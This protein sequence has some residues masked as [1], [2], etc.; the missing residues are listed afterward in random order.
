M[1]WVVIFIVLFNVMLHAAQESAPVNVFASSNNKF[2]FPTLLQQFHKHYPGVKVIVQYGAT[3]DLANAILEGVGY[4]LFLGANMK[5]PQ[6]I[7]DAKLAV[8][9][10]KRYAQGILIFLVPADATLH[11]KRLKALVDD[12]IKHITIANK[13]TAPYGKAAMEALKN[14]KMLQKVQ[15]KVVYSTD[16]ST[17]VLN[18]IWYDNAGFL[19]KSAVKTL[20]KMYNKEGVNWIEVDDNLYTPIIQGYVISKK[21]LNNINCQRFIDFIFSKEGREIY[22]EFG[23]K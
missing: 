9:P 21:G 22:K 7:Y 18:V 19:S 12:K 6:K 14:S 16:I 15:N 8:N 3:G 5:Y 2:L 13:K 4:D 1:K 11:N 20:P 23:Y 17:A 10:P